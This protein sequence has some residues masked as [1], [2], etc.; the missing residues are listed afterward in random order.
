LMGAEQGVWLE[1]LAREHDNLRAVMEGGTNRR[2][3]GWRERCGGSG[4]C[5]D[6]T[7]KDVRG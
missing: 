1:R 7:A 2:R 3:C 4:M 6:I 5:G